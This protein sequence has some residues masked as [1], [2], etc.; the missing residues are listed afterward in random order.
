M[1]KHFTT[2]EARAVLEQSRRLLEDEPCEPKPPPFEVKFE[3]ALEKWKREADEAAAQ[4][5]AADAE[6]AA[7][8]QARADQRNAAVKQASDAAF[9]ERIAL[10]KRVADLENQ[11]A[12]LS[13]AAMGFSDAATTGLHRLENFAHKLDNILEKLKTTHARELDHLRSRLAANEALHGREVALLGR[14]LD[15]ARKEVAAITAQHERKQ[16]RD[17][18]V[19]T[20][21]NVIALLQGVRQDLASRN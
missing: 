11:V 10:E 16:D 13:A 20:G 17:D 19:A 5:A 14:Q 2:K 12:E 3:D 6:R 7:A 18:I 1:A 21:N 15:D 9:A 4:R 8:E